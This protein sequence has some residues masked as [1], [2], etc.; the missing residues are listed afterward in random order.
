MARTARHALRLLERWVGAA[1]VAL[2]TVWVT[3]PRG[4][5][6]PPVVVA[7]PAAPVV[8]DRFAS[9]RLAPRARCAVSA[10]ARRPTRDPFLRVVKTPVGPAAPDAP[11]V[12]AAPVVS[13]APP[14]AAAAVLPAA[15]DETPAQDLPVAAPLVSPAPSTSG[16]E[17]GTI[18]IAGVSVSLAGLDD[19]QTRLLRT[20][21]TLPNLPTTTLPGGRYLRFGD[22]LF[23]DDC[24]N[25]LRAP[26]HAQGIDLFSEHPRFPGAN[27]VTLIREKGT[28]VTEPRVGDL[29]IFD[30]TWDRNRN[31][32]LDDPAT[33]AAIVIGFEPNGT[34]LVYNRVRSG[35][36]V[37]RMNPRYPERLT[38][39]GRRINDFLRRKR[40]TDPKGTRHLTGGLLSAYVRVLSP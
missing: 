1:G 33:H 3:T 8:S 4:P 10:R 11:A 34:V 25:V 22:Q 24:S 6:P 23:R 30:D 20:I 32:A 5:R 36:R 18:A 40:K 19:A 7:A 35:H 39:N 14:V 29:V 31:G 12:P 9:R 26:Y 15:A 2:L 17:T 21:R 38:L 37:F 16:T 13:V 28:V 27:G